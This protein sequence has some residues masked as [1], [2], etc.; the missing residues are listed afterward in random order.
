MRS[1]AIAAR[2]DLPLEVRSTSIMGVR[3]PELTWG[4]VGR[5]ML[6]RGYGLSSS[7]PTIEETAASFEGVVDQLIKVA[8]SE[9]RLQRLAEEIQRTTRRANALELVVLPQLRAEKQQIEMAL[10]ERERADHFRLKMVKKARRRQK[11]DALAASR[12]TLAR[13][14][15]GVL[16][17]HSG[18]V[19]VDIG[20]AAAGQ[21]MIAGKVG[22]DVGGVGPL[23]E[24]FD[25]FS[26]QLAPA[27]FNYYPFDF[28][29]K[30]S[31]EN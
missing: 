25:I 5:S 12:G 2:E 23:F 15:K 11:D 24:N 19:A 29:H 8:E 1:A 16:A 18:E 20:R 31:P 3:V 22:Q 26:D 6:E 14:I 17:T 4:A 30:Y 27:T 10:D 13:I 7:T 28:S 21:H 9:L